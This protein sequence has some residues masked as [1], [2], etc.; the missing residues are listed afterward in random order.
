MPRSRRS[1]R[2]TAP[3]EVS[4]SAANARCRLAHPRQARPGGALGLSRGAGP[5]RGCGTRGGGRRAAR[6]HLLAITSPAL[7]DSSRP[8]ILSRPSQSWCFIGSSAS[9]LL[10]SIN[11]LVMQARA[12]AR[13]TGW[14]SRPRAC[15]R[16]SRRAARTRR[17]SRPPTSSSPSPW[18]RPPWSPR[19][20]PPEVRQQ[21]LRAP[22]RHRLARTRSPR[23]SSAGPARGEPSGFLVVPGRAEDVAH[24]AAGDSR[25]VR[26]SS[27]SP[28]PR[29]P[30][31]PAPASSPALHNH[32]TS[33]ALPLRSCCS[34]S[35]CL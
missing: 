1:A 21:H 27:P 12:A 15:A 29:S 10:L 35:T 4:D 26:T 2:P 24:A 3:P 14:C 31:P 16:S 5:G 28:R 11:V 13:A 9:L 34:P 6:A 8:R 32:G 33:S 25:R 30:T 20:R 18:P 22:P 19:R 17:S 7:T 23:T